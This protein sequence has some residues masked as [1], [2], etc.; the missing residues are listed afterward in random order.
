MTAV[1]QAILAQAS[2]VEGGPPRLAEWRFGLLVMTVAGTCD[3]C[4][5]QKMLVEFAAEG[6]VICLNEVCNFALCHKCAT[7]LTC[8]GLTDVLPLAIPRVGVM[9]G[10]RG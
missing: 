10:E 4:G 8:G 5:S 7:V 2:N 6:M 3:G 1:P 9:A